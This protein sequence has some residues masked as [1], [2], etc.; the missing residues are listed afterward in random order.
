[1]QEICKDETHDLRPFVFRNSVAEVDT[2]ERVKFASNEALKLCRFAVASALVHRK[3]PNKSNYQPLIDALDDESIEVPGIITLNHD[4]IL[5]DLLCQHVSSY[6][7]YP[8]VDGF[9]ENAE[10]GVREFNRE[11]LWDN[12]SRPL[13]IKPH[14]S[15]S[16]WRKKTPVGHASP[17][18]AVTLEKA[19]DRL[20]SAPAECIGPGFLKDASKQEFY[21]QSI[22]QEMHQAF[23]RVLRATDVLVISGYGFGDP[24][25]NDLIYA[26]AQAKKDKKRSDNTVGSK[27]IV[28]LHKNLK[29]KSDMDQVEKVRY[30]KD[31]SPFHT[32]F[33]RILW[34]STAHFCGRWFCDATL[35]DILKAVNES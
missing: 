20:A 35:D 7:R 31:P 27:S 15:I 30:A 24:G 9:E 34:G 14:G 5:E 3:N 26:W 28:I 19:K 29:E 13:L 11:V 32:S 23:R 17:V 22:W 8:F 18:H 4:L 16:W 1:V 33:Q 12:R 21:S 10:E 2:A 25:V 6:G